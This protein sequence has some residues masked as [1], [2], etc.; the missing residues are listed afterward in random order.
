M[1]TGIVDE[2]TGLLYL[3]DNGMDT[4]L[5]QVKLFTTPLEYIAEQA[6]DDLEP[7]VDTL[8][9]ISSTLN[10]LMD[11]MYTTLQD[12]EDELVSLESYSETITGL[13]G[14]NR[15]ADDVTL[16]CVGCQTLID[17]V[18]AFNTGIGNDVAPIF[19]ELKSQI[20]FIYPVLS[21]L[22][23]G[24]DQSSD[25]GLPFVNEQVKSI[26]VLLED[27]KPTLDKL[28][29]YLEEI[30]TYG[31][32]NKLESDDGDEEEPGFYIPINRW[33]IT[34]IFSLF[35]AAIFVLVVVDGICRNRCLYKC[36][37]CMAW[38]V[39]VITWLVMALCLPAACILGDSCDFMDSIESQILERN[40]EGPLNVTFEESELLRACVYGIS[41]MDALNI[42]TDALTLES[43][44]DQL[45][46]SV[47]T[48]Q[49]VDAVLAPAVAA[50]VEAFASFDASILGFSQVD[51]DAALAACNSDSGGSY[52][53]E[54]I[55]GYSPA[56]TDSHHKN[57]NTVVTLITVKTTAQDKVDPVIILASNVQDDKSF[58]ISGTTGVLSDLDAVEGSLQKLK[59]SSAN[60][61]KNAYCDDLGDAYT[62]MKEVFCESV[63][64]ANVWVAFVF[65]FC[66]LLMI[67]MTWCLIKESTYIHAH[68]IHPLNDNHHGHSKW[69]DHAD[70]H[71][72]H[73]DPNHH[74][75]DSHPKNGGSHK[76]GGLLHLLFSGKIEKKKSLKGATSR[77]LMQNA[78]K[79]LF[80]GATPGRVKN[81]AVV[82][83]SPQ[84]QAVR[85]FFGALHPD[86]VS[87]HEFAMACYGKFPDIFPKADSTSPDRLRKAFLSMDVDKDDRVS[88]SEIVKVLGL[89]EVNLDVQS[90]FVEALKKLDCMPKVVVS[91]ELF[92]APPPQPANHLE[93]LVPA[94]AV[95]EDGLF[96]GEPEKTEGAGDEAVVVIQ[97][98]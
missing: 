53:E 48:S 84:E 56:N 93:P 22:L 65:V 38:G 96:E 49:A 25:G 70:Y 94:E 24:M 89:S 3:L 57:K 45:D 54:N 44:L 75:H 83:S 68:E 31:W 72:D 66:G 30:E 59:E 81:N 86:Y 87:G 6:F 43:S 28:T 52:T 40:P 18:T 11:P 37:Y 2:S 8:G 10:T 34:G 51:L 76:S 1:H 46:S 92:A 88:V 42:S 97:N 79:S 15:K 73:P 14:G 17:T 62:S 47:L 23:E 60:L 82:P 21:D 58:I 63:V 27:T 35:P 71:D 13:G 32:P 33:S 74:S 98:E 50:F 7:A 78:S 29:V 39:T 85:D 95:K 26:T 80:T 19:S 20:S 5:A 4:T 16:A 64:A 69:K 36:S 9:E 91:S 90:L 77:V 67:P 61:V 41:I 12:M 55:D